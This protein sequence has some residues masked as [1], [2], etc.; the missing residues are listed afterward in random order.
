MKGLRRHRARGGVETNPK[1]DSTTRRGSPNNQP[2]ALGSWRLLDDSHSTRRLT[3]DVR[4]AL[5]QVRCWSLDQSPRSFLFASVRRNPK[6]DADHETD[7]GIRSTCCGSGDGGAYGDALHIPTVWKTPALVA[8]TVATK[9][10]IRHGQYPVT[11]FGAHGSPQ[12]CVWT[13]RIPWRPQY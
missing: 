13:E 10:A 7:H 3:L 8:G 2:V 6:H 12:I 9:L 11:S 4:S 5:L 1:K